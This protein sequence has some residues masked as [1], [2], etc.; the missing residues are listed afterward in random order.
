MHWAKDI[1]LGDA[2]STTLNHNIRILGRKGVLVL[3][4]IAGMVQLDVINSKLD[5]VLAIADFKTGSTYDNF[6]P[7]IDE[8]AAYGAGVFLKSLFNKKKKDS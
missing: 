6:D 5:S 4:F 7:N 8:I 3:N 2:P 1:R